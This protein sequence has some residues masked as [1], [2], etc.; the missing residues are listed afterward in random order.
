MSIP[1][2]PPRSRRLLHCA[3]AA[4]LLFTACVNRR[5]EPDFAA[6]STAYAR[7]MN[8]QMLLNLARLDQGHPAYFMAIGEIRI[9]RTQSI[10]LNS[11][12][13]SSHTEGQSVTGTI[14]RTVS[15]VLSGTLTPNVS[16]NAS[17]TFI[18]IP[19]NST[20]TAKQ[21]LEP[22][23]IEVFNTLYQQGWPVD[24]LLR[25]LVERIEVDL[26]DPEGQHTR[27]VLTN[28]PTR[29]ESW[30]R[31][32]RFLRA[33][34][35][36]RELQK[37]G[38]LRLRS[39]EVPMPASRTPKTAAA[40]AQPGAGQNRRANPSNDGAEAEK[41]D[42]EKRTED[43]TPARTTHTVY[44][45]ISDQAILDAVLTELNRDPAYRDE[46][47]PAPPPPPKTSDADAP[48]KNFRMVFSSTLR[49]GNTPVVEA[50]SELEAERKPAKPAN[51]PP[52]KNVAHTV[53]VLRSFRSVLDAV[54]Q[55]QRA[56]DQLAADDRIAFFSQ[57][58]FRQRRPVL[59]TDWTN[60]KGALL[61][62]V[63]ELKFAGVRYQ[64]TDP[65]KPR[66]NPD[67][68][69]RGFPAFDARWNRDVFRLLI[70]LSSQVN[71]DITKF[72][73]QTLELTP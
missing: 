24:Q 42:G 12:G 17:P 68:A 58:P 23:S 33:C 49:V 70:D 39:D 11:S 59:R 28:S 13:N 67:A 57:L 38:G 10:G 9:P 66:D 55:E 20:E 2:T 72:Q 54:A 30:D 50:G 60:E 34:E 51:T 35:V 45:F 61:A 8:W 44:E 18:F 16:A 52:P 29:A 53:L 47:A 32:A 31:F 5:L 63:A 25:V 41:A 7:D 56:F 40:Q 6:F 65:V 22:I 26:Y 27:L 69:A 1:S 73:R 48:L 19:I 43:K 3:A 14:T 21:L 15:N 37:R 62:P 46:Y 71:V 4:A 36:V 64:I